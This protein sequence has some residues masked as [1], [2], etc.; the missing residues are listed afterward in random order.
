MVLIEENTVNTKI[1]PEQVIESLLHLGHN[2]TLK[3]YYK[4]KRKGDSAHSTNCLYSK[5]RRL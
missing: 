5:L 1:Q 2:M 3:Y 4:A